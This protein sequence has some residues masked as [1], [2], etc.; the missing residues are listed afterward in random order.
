MQF[1]LATG[2]DE[3]DLRRLL[4][5]TPFA[6]SI[7]LSLEREPCIDRA[8]A[9]EGENHQTIVVR[10]ES[11]GHVGAM[12]TRTLA[13]RYVNGAAMRL[14]YL[15]Q[16][17][18]SSQYRAS[19]TLLRRGYAMLRQLHADEASPFYITSIVLDNRPA[20]RFLEAGLPGMPH[21]ELVDELVTMM[22][23]TRRFVRSMSRSAN[24]ECATTA[25]LPMLADCLARY[26][27]RYQFSPVWTEA[28]LASPVRTRDLS[29]S[30]F[31]VARVSGRIVGCLACWDQRGFKQA[32]VRGYDRWLKSVRPVANLFGSISGTPKL[33]AVGESVPF[34][35]LSHLGVD[36][37]D[38]DVFLSLLDSVLS[39]AAERDIEI[40]GL[41][42]SAR[43]PLTSVALGHYKARTY[44]SR[45]YTVY[46]P[47]GAAAAAA[48][49]ERPTHLEAAIL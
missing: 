2:A 16:L 14:G 4:R 15:G 25:D 48:L 27:A 8:N 7:E 36:D 22:F 11:D 44:S 18:V 47:D 1:D 32:V 31:V 42:L 35:Y 40:V 24:V 39:L 45:V 17:R 29:A 30:D 41:G 12:G 34:A 37:D 3:A 20:R 19:P 5:E 6:G 28:D 38:P 10:S 26:G 43:N 49:D 21:Y 33:P 9:V 46:W 13:S 23:S